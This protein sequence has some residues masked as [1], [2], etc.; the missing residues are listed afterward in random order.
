VIDDKGRLTGAITLELVS[1][2]NSGRTPLEA[3]KAEDICLPLEPLTTAMTEEQIANRLLAS[4]DGM[5]PII[6]PD[7]GKLLGIVNK[8]NAIR[9]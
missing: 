1:R 2:A 8:E 7:S 3:L 6:D 4:R 5:L 9:S